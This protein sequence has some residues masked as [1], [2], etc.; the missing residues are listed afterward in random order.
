MSTL[1]IV[2]VRKRVHL[3]S[4]IETVK[5]LTLEKERKDKQRAC[6]RFRCRVPVRVEIEKP[7]TSVKI[8]DAS[9]YNISLEGLCFLS[10]RNFKRDEKLHVTI[11]TNEMFYK[12]TGTVTHST[13]AVDYYKTGIRFDLE[14]DE[15]PDLD[16]QRN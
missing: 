4:F 7:Q 5:F 2:Q 8:F 3:Q 9:M 13:Y 15:S 1:T 12:V 10:I 16:V 11:E 14:K 6:W